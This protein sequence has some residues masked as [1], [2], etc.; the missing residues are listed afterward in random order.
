MHTFAIINC[1]L[2]NNDINSLDSKTSSV[3]NL[4]CKHVH[5]LN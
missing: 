5:V 3:R 4:K 1:D 2:F